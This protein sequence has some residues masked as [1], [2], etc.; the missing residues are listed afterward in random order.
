MI[1]TKIKRNG[2]FEHAFWLQILGDHSW[3]ILNALSPKET[4]F[5]DKAN[6]FID[7]FDCLLKKS[8][9]SSSIEN[10]HELNYQAYSSAMKIREFKLS[11][12]AKMI[13][14]KISINMSPTFVNHMV[15]ELEEYICI[16][17]ALING[18]IPN[19]SDIHLHLLWISD[20][21]DH[22]FIIY[23]SLDMTEKELI[24]KGHMYSKI[25][26]LNKSY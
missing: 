18:S 20:G 8:H 4:D 10:L 12:I 17:N 25:F 7:L 6:E 21:A 24:N 3:F 11:I 22:A 13:E 19:T 26:T 1:D 15:N 16:L 9:K 5:I 23:R 14:D 2:I